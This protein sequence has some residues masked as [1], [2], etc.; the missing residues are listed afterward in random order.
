MKYIILMFMS[1]WVVACAAHDE[2]Y[3]RLHPDALHKEIKNCP[4]KQPKAMR[5]DQLIAIAAQVNELAYQ[6]RMNPQ[7]FGQQIIALQIA[8]AKQEQSLQQKTDQPGLD[9]EFNKNRQNLN[10]RLAVVKWLESPES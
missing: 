4:D 1:L 9:V 10:E 7:Q 5:C 3:Y 6:L 2:S 8:L